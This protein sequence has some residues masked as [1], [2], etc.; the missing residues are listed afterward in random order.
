VLSWTATL[1]FDTGLASEDLVISQFPGLTFTNAIALQ[2]GVSL[3]EFEFPPHSGEFVV[4]D[5]LDY[6]QIRFATPAT[7]FSA[8]FTYVARLT[9]TA[10]DASDAIVASATSLFSSN[11]VL[12]GEAGSTSNELLSL[13]A[14][15]ISR[16]T[17]QGGGGGDSFAMDDLTYD[18]VPEPGMALSVCA[19][20]LGLLAIRRRRRS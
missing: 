15:D 7:E 14:A 8:Y 12:S 11:A 20:L 4:G 3:N 19:G 1:D 16:V 9:L 17:I 13:T 10:Y 6:L 18:A 2:S 5:H